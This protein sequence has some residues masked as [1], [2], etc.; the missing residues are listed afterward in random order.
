MNK[1]AEKNG[2]TAKTN[3]LSKIVNILPRIKKF[4]NPCD[5]V[6]L[7]LK[8]VAK[9]EVIDLFSGVNDGVEFNPFGVINFP[10]FKMGNIDSLNLFNFDE[11]II[12]SFYYHN[13]LLYKNFIDI[14]GNIGLHSIIAGK[15]GYSVRTY[16][17]DQIHFEVLQENIKN[18]DL[19]DNVKLIRAAV[20]NKKGAA[21]FTRVLDNT[22]GSHLTH[23]K[24]NPYGPLEEIIVDKENIVDIIFDKPDLLKID[25]E[26]H[27]CEIICAIPVEKWCDFDAIV[28]IGSK[29]NAQR[30]F[31]FFTNTN[32]NMFSQKN[33]WEK[34]DRLGDMPFGHQD[35]SLFISTKNVMPW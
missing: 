3:F 21:A 29:D 30:I 19:N 27:E 6:Y 1:I 26:G 22:T 20:S 31:N 35:G 33:N 10:Y 13:K 28:E 14:G 12:F 23:S 5:D 9:K 25:A 34:V 18:N 11:L 32:V 15:L 2:D 24:K 17:P 8:D 7:L 4:H 16:E